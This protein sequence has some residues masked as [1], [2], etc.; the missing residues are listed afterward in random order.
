MNDASRA[1]ATAGDNHRILL[2]SSPQAILVHRDFVPRYANR[3]LAELFGYRDEEEVPGLASILELIVSAEHE[4]M[5]VRNRNRARHRGEHV[6]RSIELHCKRKDE[7]IFWAEIVADL[8]SF[9]G[10]VCIQTCIMDITRR[11]T[12]EE[13]LTE[14]RK[15]FR[16]VIDTLPMFV[17]V[18][19]IDSNYVRA[20]GSMCVCRW[21]ESDNEP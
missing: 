18:K 14:S 19:D 3:A 17:F 8:V 1:N 20:Q 7:T 21:T 2:D 6:S 16:T 5:R 12:A 15:L 13:Q 11:R 9:D 4:H 10:E